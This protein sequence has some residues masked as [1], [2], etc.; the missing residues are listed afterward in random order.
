[1]AEHAGYGGNFY[2][3]ATPGTSIGAV[4]TVVAGINNWTVNY[5]ADVHETTDFADAGVKTYVAGCTG[6]AG[7]ATGFYDS[8]VSYNATYKPGENFTARLEMTSSKELLGNIIMTGIDFG[9]AV[10]G[11]VTVNFTFQGYGAVTI[12]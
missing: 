7:T 3:H 10:S 5:T 9:T 11:A 4:T 12:A 8:T 2:L 6:W 1:M